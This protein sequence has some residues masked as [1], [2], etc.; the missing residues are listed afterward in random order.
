MTGTR[1][2]WLALGRG[3][4]PWWDV[5]GRT[6]RRR[7]RRRLVD[8]VLALAVAA[9]LVSTARTGARAAGVSVNLD[10]WAPLAGAWQNGNLNGN[11][12]R[13]PAGGVVPFRVALEGIQPSAIVGELP[14]SALAPRDPAAPQP[15]GPATPGSPPGVSAPRGPGG[16]GPT[17]P[18]TAT[19]PNAPASNPEPIGAAGV[20]PWL[21]TLGAMLVGLVITTRRRIRR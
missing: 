9:L 16:A 19:V 18:P 21:A 15:T 3:R 5:T 6:A 14:P 17:V 4:D 11:N 12:A 10:Q 13:F 1:P 8:L 20:V 2:L 7:A